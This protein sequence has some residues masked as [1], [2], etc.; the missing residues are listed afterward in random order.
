MCS[1]SP[2]TSVFLIKGDP[3]LHLQG[4]AVPF[5]KHPFSLA[6]GFYLLSPGPFWCQPLGPAMAW[7]R[8]PSPPREQE[9][10]R[11]QVLETTSSCSTAR[12]SKLTGNS[13]TS[14]GLDVCHGKSLLFT[15]F[16]AACRAS[17]LRRG[18]IPVLTRL[19]S[20]SLALGHLFQLGW[21]NGTG[22]SRQ[23][24]DG[25]ALPLHAQRLQQ[26]PAFPQGIQSLLEDKEHERGSRSP[27]EHTHTPCC[28]P[29][30]ERR[31]QTNPR[32]NPPSAA[33]RPRDTRIPSAHKLP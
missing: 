7:Q 10:T 18:R 16:Q 4:E 12:Y 8:E 32:G 19:C 17:C 3:S 25:S 14:C 20:F 33:S 30:E 1:Y 5:S 28:F 27:A 2:H 24:A 21:N 23:Q 31:G 22:D 13:A 15:A 29:S 26:L 11:Q 6:V 9:S